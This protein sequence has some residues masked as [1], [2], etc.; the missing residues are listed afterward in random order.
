M[1]YKRKIFAEK[2]NDLLCLVK[3]INFNPDVRLFHGEV[4]LST[5][6]GIWMYFNITEGYTLGDGQN[7]DFKYDQKIG[8]IEKVLLTL[9]PQDGVYVDVGSNNG[10]FYSLKIATRYPE[11]RVIAFEPDIGI[12]KHFEKNIAINAINNVTIYNY[13]LGENCDDRFLTKGRD[14]SNYLL[15]VEIGGGIAAQTVKVSSLDNIIHEMDLE[16]IFAIK[17][18]IEGLEADFLKGAINTIKKYMPILVM[19]L[20][21]LLLQRSGSSKEIALKY[22]H[23]LGYETVLVENSRDYVFSPIGCGLIEDIKQISD[24]ENRI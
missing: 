5:R 9:M 20:D 16:S 24:C 2:A 14:A 4:Y 15:P 10:Y 23:E 18:D 1:I 22:I 6:D 7:R 21:D 8:V 13:A 11:S 3:E 17:V 12:L 19:E